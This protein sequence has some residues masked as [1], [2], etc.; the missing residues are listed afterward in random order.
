MR[1]GDAISHECCHSSDHPRTGSETYSTDF[2]LG[3]HEHR[4]RTYLP[5]ERATFGVFFGSASAVE[6]SASPDGNVELS[7]PPPS[8]FTRSTAA[9]MR[10]C[11][12]VMAFCWSLSA[13]V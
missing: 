9:L 3:S 11:R 13:M 8:A 1:G 10:R 4:A 7:H 2:S 5:V 6:R 12:M